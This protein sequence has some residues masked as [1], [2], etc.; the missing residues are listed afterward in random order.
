MSTP[1][2]HSLSV[3]AVA[4]DVASA[5]RAHWKFLIPA[6]IIVLLPQALA[7]G[8]LD[9]LEVGASTVPGTWRSSRRP[10]DRIVNL[11]GQAF[12]ADV[13]SRALIPGSG[14][15]ARHSRSAAASPA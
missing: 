5:Y 15:L 12:Y 1:P 13:R 10:A 7:D 14:R 3:G 4:R 8:F 2:R 9:H 6:A 11:F